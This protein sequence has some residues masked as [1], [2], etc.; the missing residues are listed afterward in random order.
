[1]S[2]KEEIQ[3][4]ATEKVMTKYDKKKIRR[5]QE[6]IREQREKKTTT[7]I[8]IAILVA[9]VGLVLI[10]PINTWRTLHGAFIEVGGEKVTRVE[11]DYNYNVTKNNYI[12]Q[13]AT[14]LT[15]FGI[16]PST[17]FTD[18]VYSDGLT[19][20][21]FFE[22]LAVESI[23]QTKAMVADAKS[24]GFTYNTDEDYKTY[25]E[26][27]AEAAEGNGMKENEY[28]SNLFGQYAT[29]DRVE[30][31][32]RES[33][34]LSAYNDKLIK[35]NK[36]SPEE[37]EAYYDENKESYDVVDYHYTK[38]EAVLPTGEDDAEP[39]EDEIFRAMEAAEKTANE[40]EAT[41]TEEGEEV[42]AARKT[43]CDVIIRNWLFDDERK[44]GDT[45]TLEDEEMHC[46]FVVS[47]EKK[48]R[49]EAQTANVRMIALEG[50]AQAVLDEYNAKGATEDAF[51]ALYDEKSVADYGE[52]G[53]FENVSTATLSETFNEWI[54]ADGRKSGDVGIISFTETAE[55]L[56]YYVSEGDPV[57]YAEIS[58]V[59]INEKVEAYISELMD[60]VEVKDKGNLNYVKV[61]AQKAAESVEESVEVV[62]V[63]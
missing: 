45:A 17:D 32:V 34:F 30:P 42:L 13:N 19:W 39:T 4:E 54:F 16:D 23:K 3:Q 9:I 61:E 43:S 25:S 27:L 26:N 11:F 44:P 7:G 59:L 8:T 31:F 6:K 56:V 49:D 22:E 36:P 50:G 53:L 41:V 35:D 12:N 18:Q 10:A 2:K 46:Y 52:G 63:E 62:P 29:K 58:E 47:F 33:L 14:L 48:Y 28:L 5:E 21:D 37:V 20:K 24:K 1:M 15:Y 55:F 57:Y 51:I 60:A 38:V 40:K